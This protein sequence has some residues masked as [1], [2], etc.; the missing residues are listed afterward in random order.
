[1]TTI[2]FADPASAIRAARQIE[3]AHARVKGTLEEDIGPFLPRFG[4]VMQAARG[5]V[6]REIEELDHLSGEGLD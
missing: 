6:A 3:K 5:S 4:R 2:T 1:M